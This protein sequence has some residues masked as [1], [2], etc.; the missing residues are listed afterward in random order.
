MLR[1][2]M[3]GPTTKQNANATVAGTQRHGVLAVAGVLAAGLMMLG[4]GQ[5]RAQ[6]ASVGQQSPSFQLPSK[7][8]T[9]AKVTYDNR[10]EVYGGLN[11]M[12]FQAGQSLPKRMN[13][14]GGELLAT[15][16]LNRKVGLALNYRGEAGTT[17]VFPGAQQDPYNISRPLVYM[18]M[19]MV[20]AQYRGPKNQFVAIDYHG[21]IGASKGVFDASKRANQPL[22]Y[23]LTGLYTNRTKPVAAVGGSLDI[24]LSKRTAIRLS[25][26]LIFEHFG[27]ETREFFAISGGLVY[28]FGKQ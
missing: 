22:F 9:P 24:N 28:R 16:W 14:G 13:L 12:N 26:D 20:G 6:G 7:I 17:P 19:L 5:M 23:P 11:F 4:A 15:Y 3:A 21:F 18:N 1:L 25:P 10:Y 27:T 2:M 8:A